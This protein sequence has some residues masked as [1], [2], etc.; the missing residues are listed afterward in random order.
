MLFLSLTAGLIFGTYHFIQSEYFAKVMVGHLEEKVLSQGKV[1][2]NFKQMKVGLFPPSTTLLDA[3]ITI[4]KVK[5]K[6]AEVGM[7]FGWYDL[8]TRSKLKAEKVYVKNGKVDLTDLPGSNKKKDLKEVKNELLKLMSRE[9]IHEKIYYYFKKVFPIEISNIQLEQTLIID[10]NKIWD[11]SKLTLGIYKTAILIDLQLENLKVFPENTIENLNLNAQLTRKGLRIVDF[12]IRYE[13]TTLAGMLELTLSKNIKIEGR[14]RVLAKDLSLLSNKLNIFREVKLKGKG[15]FKIDIRGS[16]EDPVV[17]M[18]GEVENFKSIY[19]DAKN[20]KLNLLKM[21]DDISLNKLEIRNNDELLKLRERV[22]VYSL[23]EKKLHKLELGLHLENLKVRT[24][25]KF[26]PELTSSLK[27][28]LKGKLSVIYNDSGLTFIP[29]SGMELNKMRLVDSIGDPILKASKVIFNSSKFHLAKNGK[30]TIDYDLDYPGARIVG[31][32]QIDSD[33]INFDIYETEINFE[34]FGEISGVPIL[35]EGQIKCT[36]GGRKGSE[37]IDLKINMNNLSLVNIN[38]GEVESK[39]SYKFNKKELKIESLLAKYPNTTYSGDGVLSFSKNPS[40]D[41]KLNF[42]NGTFYEAEKI[43]EKLLD[44]K[45]LTTYL[46]GN[47]SSRFRI[48]GG[49][50]VD[51]LIITGDVESNNGSILNEK[52]DSLN[53]GFLFKS[54]IINI[55]DLGVRLYDGH[56]MGGMHFNFLDDSFEYDINISK[57]RLKKINRYARLGLGLNGELVASFYGS[58]NLKDYSTRAAISLVN[59][60]IGAKQYENTKITIYSTPQDLYIK[61]VVAGGLSKIDSFIN[62]ESDNKKDSFINISVNSE[63]L[64]DL[65]GFI[66]EHNI[67][68]RTTYGKLNFELVSEFNWNDIN[69]LDAILTVNQFSFYNKDTKIMSV[70]DNNYAIIKN[71]KIKEWNL[72]FNGND[73]YIKSTVDKTSKN[74]AKVITDFSL[75]PSFLEIF[76]PKLENLQGKIDG[77]WILIRENNNFINQLNLTGSNLKL[78]LDELD[79]HIN[80]LNFIMNVE[81]NYITISGLNGKYGKGDF[82]GSGTIVIKAPYPDINMQFDIDNIFISQFKRSGVLLSGKAQ[83]IGDNRPYLFKGDFVIPFGEVLDEIREFNFITKTRELKNKFIPI[84]KKYKKGSFLKYNIKFN[85]TNPITVRNSFVDIKIKGSGRLVGED[86]SKNLKA[87]FEIV[88]TYSKFLLK[89]NEFILSKGKVIFGNDNGKQAVNLDVTGNTQIGDYNIGL[90]LSGPVGNIT[91][92]FRSDPDLPQ[93]DILSLLTLGITTKESK[94]LQAND[95]Q[96][97]TSISIGNL[98]A[99]QLGVNKEL[100]KSFGIKISILPEFS[101]NE[102]TPITGRT[103]GGDT[104]VGKIKS[105]SKIRLQKRIKKVDLSFSSTIGGSIEQKQEM[106]I[107]YNINKDVSIQGVY[108]INIGDENQTD[109][110]PDSLGIDLIWKKTFK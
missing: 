110:N 2:V 90:E 78:K 3:S 100:N 91:I 7:F 64:R 26:L 47:F 94:E 74:T 98:I 25:L 105:G 4:K 65:L 84:D 85:A 34:K 21:G 27:G 40:I 45:K 106:N 63:D 9:N 10:S 48:E 17:K 30:L 44:G 60:Q 5:V 41:A 19:L 55:M 95:L 69:S 24:A 79:G 15:Y 8:F 67:K 36:I 99:E 32:G 92:N 83:I 37:T 109:E 104:T 73:E 86:H 13:N 70:D 12:D 43:F 50:K 39:L 102:I 54:N 18:E 38:F 107:N 20:I 51:E 81:D 71:G 61:A 29:I 87:E 49:L 42:I 33:K 23:R 53:I 52:Y 35:G 1:N 16:L 28:E 97:I 80:N 96:S 108:E 6:A 46:T 14:V 93:Q 56:I 22:D 89:G 101:T 72:I 77:K 103:H 58:G 82:N 31:E 66:S 62:Y 75:S 11:I 59:S 76:R 68:K 88:P 57:V